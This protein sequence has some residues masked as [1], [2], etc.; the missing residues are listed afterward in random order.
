MLTNLDFKSTREY[1]IL[2]RNCCFYLELVYKVESVQA[3]VDFDKVLGIDYGLNNWLTCVSNVGT[4]FIV[5]GLR[6]KSQNQWYNKRVVFLKEDKPTGFWSNRLANLTEKRNRQNR[7]SMNKVA[8]IAVN[9]C[10]QNRIG[11]IVLGW[12][13]GQKDG[14]NMGKK[15]NQSFV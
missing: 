9:H 7:D 8:R 2:P 13:K 12:N 3:D 15:T 14:A 10:I 11:T 4:S 6:I 5:N 1:R